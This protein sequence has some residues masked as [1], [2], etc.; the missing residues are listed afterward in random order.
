[1]KTLKE[2]KEETLS[3]LKEHLED[4]IYTKLLEKVKTTET[5]DKFVNPKEYEAAKEYVTEKSTKEILDKFEENSISFI[6][7]FLEHKEMITDNV[8]MLC[9]LLI[10]GLYLPFV[11]LNEKDKQGIKYD[12]NKELSDRL[13][14]ILNNY[15]LYITDTLA[16]RDKLLKLVSDVEHNLDKKVKNE[17][18]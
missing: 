9:D 17:N 2:F 6:H 5:L 12:W 7:M 10:Q 4:K 16:L 15:Y 8:N 13:N 14:V 11:I 3:F 18:N 1:M